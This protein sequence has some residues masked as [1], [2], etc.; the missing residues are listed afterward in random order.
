MSN[1][2]NYAVGEVGGA[3]APTL[4]PQDNNSPQKLI[5]LDN[6]D[7]NNKLLLSYIK[8]ITPKFFTLEDCTNINSKTN[9]IYTSVNMLYYPDLKIIN[10]S[11]YYA[12][13]FTVNDINNFQPF[14]K[15]PSEIPQLKNQKMIYNLTR[16]SSTST[17]YRNIRQAMDAHID[18]DNIFWSDYIGL[19]ASTPGNRFEGSCIIDLNG[20]I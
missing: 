19:D 14:F 5:T 11:M 6:L 20:Y 18:T 7:H 1:N 9:K 8:S 15:L 3:E 10:L 17:T 4:P 2:E 12:I 16:R 13:D